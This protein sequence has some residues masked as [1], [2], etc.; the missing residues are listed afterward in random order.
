VPSGSEEEADKK[1]GFMETNGLSGTMSNVQQMLTTT[2][3]WIGTVQ[4]LLAEFGLKIVAAILIFLI[5]RWVARLIQRMVANM[6]RRAKVDA[7]VVSF[8]SNLIYAV[9]LIFVILAALGQVGVET[10]S[11]IA[12]LGAAGLAVGLAL[13]GSLANFAM[14][15]AVK[16]R[17]EAEGLTIPFPQRDVH[18]YKHAVD[19]AG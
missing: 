3:D 14:N 17:L 1:E 7:A 4:E 18:L 11:V 2:P 13:Q 10:T 12:M 5:G 8:A 16:K 6:L 19:A 15:E 9:L